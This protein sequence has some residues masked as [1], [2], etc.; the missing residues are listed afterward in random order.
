MSNTMRTAL[1]RSGIV[2]GVI[3]GLI[4]VAATAIYALSEARA[5]KVYSVSPVA[6]SIPTDSASLE[7]GRHFAEAISDCVG[8]HGANLAGGVV[9]N[10]PAIGTVYARNL[11]AGQGGS[12]GQFTDADWVKAIRHGIRP[13]GRSLW[14]MPS[15]DYHNLAD[16]DLAAIIAYVKTRP[17]VDNVLPEPRLGPLGRVLTVLGAL[18]LFSAE[19]TDQNPIVPAAPE[20]GITVEYGSYLV[21][22][23]GCSGCHGPDYAGGSVPGSPPEAPQAPNLTPAGSLGGWTADEFVQTLRTGLRPDGRP[24]VGDMPWQAY[25]QMTDDELTAVY[26]YLQ[27]LPAVPTER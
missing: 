15:Y 3:A 22:S 16:D 17:P 18:P 6:V 14:I 25:G 13:T 1:R 23:A 4:V 19:L 9:F 5:N 20:P 27:S 26:L 12:G 8:C 21:R 11:T 10:D 2:L 7:R 24:L